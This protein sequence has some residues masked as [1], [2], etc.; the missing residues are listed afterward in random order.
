MNQ[1]VRLE[2][3]AFL[4]RDLIGAGLVP[5][6]YYGRL[7]EY[8][9]ETSI[10]DRMLGQKLRFSAANSGLPIR[11]R[12]A[13]DLLIH[14]G[15]YREYKARA[16]LAKNRKHT[17]R[18]LFGSLSETALFLNEF[19]DIPVYGDFGKMLA[20]MERGFSGMVQAYADCL[21][22]DDRSRVLVY[23]EEKNGKSDSATDMGGANIDEQFGK[24]WKTQAQSIAKECI[25]HHRQSDLFPT[26]DDVCEHVASVMREK[27]IYGLHGKPLEPN[28]IKRNA[29]QGAWWKQNKP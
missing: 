17:L 9:I 25:S 11:Q 8:D 18:P 3:R 15:L 27:Q 20:S 5:E 16:E 23:I 26:Q 1:F 19:D 22:E 24:D 7:R 14:F 12:R 28:Y 13:S 4:L 6:N 10:L 21:P 2:L 29:I